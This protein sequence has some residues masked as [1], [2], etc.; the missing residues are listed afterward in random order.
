MY[1]KERKNLFH[2]P[3]GH[4]NP[5]RVML[6]LLIIV[7]LIA[8]LR[9]YAQGSIWPPLIPTPT[10]TRTVNSYVVEGS[11][12][13]QAGNLDKAIEA[14]QKAVAVDSTDPMLFVEL[15]KI[16][17]Y[18]SN[19]LTTD[20]EIQTRL[21]EALEAINQAKAL[22]PNNSTVLAVR[23]FVL[24]WNAEA[25]Q[26]EDKSEEF[27][28]EA[29]AEALMA[30]QMDNA[31][32]LAM[33]YYAEILTDQYKWVQA[34]EYMDQA[35]ETGEDLMDVHRIQGYLYEVLGEYNLA[36]DEYKKAIEIT[37]NLTFLYNS[38][39]VLYRYLEQYDTAL[40]YFDKAASLN[41]QLGIKDPI[42]YMAI[43][44]TYIRMGEAMVASRNAYKAL[45]INPYNADTYGRVGVI[46]YRARNYEGS[47]PA[48]QCAVVGCDAEVSCEAR[49]CD[50]ATE[51]PI[52]LVGLPLSDTTVAYY[53]TYG[54]VLSGLH[55]PGDDKCD[56]AAVVFDEIRAMYADQPDYMSIVEAGEEICQGSE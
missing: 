34:I 7:M 3:K 45:E 5:Y 39:G 18:S 21:T 12:H 17:V 42:P 33:A 23:A 10:P 19:T 51:E 25:I 31:N 32:T 8:V 37:P 9:G 50:S 6:L 35:M 41:E 48:L 14:Y 36:I 56:R 47:I 24:D 46:Y 15:A 11:T 53:L 49:E 54:S 13:F 22:A 55:R 28:N 1:I 43:A 26:E 20:A 40:E 38:V 52:V 4:S 44:N 30:L 2:D 16:Q 29:E 27:L